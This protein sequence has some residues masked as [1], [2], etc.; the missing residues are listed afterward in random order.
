[1]RQSIQL[2]CRPQDSVIQSRSQSYPWCHL[3]W[4]W[5]SLQIHTPLWWSPWA[6]S[7]FVHLFMGSVLSKKRRHAYYLAVKTLFYNLNTPPSL[8]HTPVSSRDLVLCTCSFLVSTGVTFL[9]TCKTD[10][11]I[12]TVSACLWE[13]K[14]FIVH[15]AIFHSCFTSAESSL[16]DLASVIFPP[17]VR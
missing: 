10:S 5:L 2:A 17:L 13:E 14:Q 16:L 3:A 4:A 6:G 7:L 1:M 11:G 8:V 12:L 9:Q 15:W